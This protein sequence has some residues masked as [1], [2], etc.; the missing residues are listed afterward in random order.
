MQGAYVNKIILIPA[1]L[2]LSLLATATEQDVEKKAKPFKSTEAEKGYKSEDIQTGWAFGQDATV[3]QKQDEVVL[4]T[5]KTKRDIATILEESLAV[6]KEQLKEQKKIRAILEE[7]FDPKP[8]TI[9]KDDGTECVANSSAD[10][11]EFPL[12]AEAKRV[13]VMANYLKDPHDEKAVGE[14]KKWFSVYLNHTFDIGRA[15][16]YDTAENGSNTFKTDFKRDGYDSPNGF[17]Y[18]AKDRHNS[19]LINAFGNRGLSVKIL[20]GKTTDLDLYAMDEIAMFIKTHSA[21]PVELVFLDRSSAEV[22]SGGARSLDFVGRAFSQKNVSKRIGTAADFPSSL[23]ATPA[24][25]VSFKDAKRSKTKIIKSGKASSSKLA[26]SIIEWMIFEKIVDPAQ[27][28]DSRIWKDSDENYG[29]KYIK[30]M[31][32]KDMKGSIR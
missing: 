32:G 21:L 14:W 15:G 30:E 27:L 2:C 4:K 7:Q 23:Q 17:Y 20:L 5:P 25:M 6:Q 22:Y 3:Q 18:G 13:P 9:K 31:Y 1:I 11:F 26:N 16:E 28:N 12:I 19:R 24:Y 10:C 8:H 29:A